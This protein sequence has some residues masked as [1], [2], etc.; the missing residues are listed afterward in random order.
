MDICN[1]IY[2]LIHSVDPGKKRKLKISN[3]KTLS[4]KF[5]NSD[6]YACI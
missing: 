6:M 5:Y 1:G 2:K 4:T 3:D